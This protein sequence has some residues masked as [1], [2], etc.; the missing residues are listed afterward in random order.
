MLIDRERIIEPERDLW[1]Q[2]RN[3]QINKNFG[4]AI[5]R[6]G[7]RKEICMKDLATVD[8][9]EGEY[10]VCE[11]LNGEMTDIPLKLF[12]EKVSE[13]DI[14]DIEINLK[15]GQQVITVGE[16][17]EQE[18]EIRRK[19]IL[20]KLNRINKHISCEKMEKRDGENKI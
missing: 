16:K 11:L 9:I 7:E 4:E 5:K 15:D 6:Y 3:K 1:E 13:G 10:A 8:R 17:N 14:F 12:K 2:R 19:I 18:M 20:E